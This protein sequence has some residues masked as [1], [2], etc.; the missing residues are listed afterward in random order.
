MDFYSLTGYSLDS[1]KPEETE[2]GI[3][4]SSW[5]LGL[6]AQELR[7]VYETKTMLLKRFKGR[8]NILDDSGKS[9]DV[10]IQYQWSQNSN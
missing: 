10:D 9:Q 5:I 4:A 7:V 6:F 1:K 2:F 8:S 3:R